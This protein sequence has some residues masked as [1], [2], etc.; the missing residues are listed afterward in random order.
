[1]TFLPIITRELRAQSRQLFTYWIRVIGVL[2]LLVGGLILVA[3]HAGDPNLGGLLFSRM[4]LLGYISI[5]LCVPIAAADCIARERRE[6]TLG[7]LYLSRLRPTGIVVAKSVAHGWRGMTLVVATIPALAIPFLAGGVSGAQLALSALAN[8][9]ALGWCLSAAIVTSALVRNAGAAIFLAI[10]L[11][12][13]GFLLLPWII[14][15]LLGLNSQTTWMAG[16]SQGAYDF[17]VGLMVVANS[18]ASATSVFRFYKLGQVFQAVFTTSAITASMFVLALIFAAQRVRHSWKDEPPSAR[19]ERVNTVLF[20]PRFGLPRFRRL[21]SRQLERNPVGWLEHL[22]WKGRMLRWVVLGFVM[23]RSLLALANPIEYYDPP[24]RHVVTGWILLLGLTVYVI[25]SF[26]RERETGLLELLLVTPMKTWEIIRGRLLA[27]WS[28]FL[29]AIALFVG[30]WSYCIYLSRYNV[31]FIWRGDDVQP[32]WFFI[33]SFLTVPMIGLYFSL[34]CRQ[35]VS[36]FVLTVVNVFVLPLV[37]LLGLA[38]IGWLVDASILEME[39]S[40]T[41]SVWVRVVMVFVAM[42]YL[43]RL[44]WRLERRSFRLER[45][46]A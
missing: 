6:G 36:A 11:A 1:M 9:N 18:S 40:L 13:G 30:I 2:A 15:A 21:R 45:E 46:M 29:P 5:W 27:L 32:V 41:Q 8:L 12:M 7:L 34:R 20:Q 19:A 25:G 26:R 22:S 3:Q 43:F 10:A 24:G 33:I 38:F 28:A 17:F 35:Q 16:Y 23:W 44:F 14:G 39:I 31:G 37:P 42:F 4:H